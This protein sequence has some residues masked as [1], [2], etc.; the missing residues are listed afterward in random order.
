MHMTRNVAAIIVA[1][2]MLCNGRPPAQAA[3][4][5]DLVAQHMVGE[6]LLAAHLVALAEKSGM[7]KADI[8]AIL[9]RIAEK[10]AIEEFW[11]T[12]SSGHAYLTNT[13]VDFTFSPDSTKQP[14]ASAF[15]PLISGDKAIVIQAA[16]KREIDNRI[17]KYVGV[18]GIDQPRIVQVG[19]PAETVVNCK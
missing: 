12:D 16:R 8:D 13:G 6:A 2:I 14:Q 1:L 15:W 3:D 5:E 17:F 11:I 9:K 10:S 18:A 4:C 7:K 19:I